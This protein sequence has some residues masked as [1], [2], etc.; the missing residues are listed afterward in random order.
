MLMSI[1]LPGKQQISK[2]FSWTTDVPN[3]KMAAVEEMYGGAGDEDCEIET[4]NGPWKRK[5]GVTKRAEMKM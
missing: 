2:S 1:T 4:T 3:A 5:T